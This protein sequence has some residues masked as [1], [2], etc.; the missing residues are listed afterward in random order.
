M[1][2]SAGARDVLGGQ[3]AVDPRP[4]LHHEWLAQVPGEARGHDAGHGVGAAARRVG[5]DEAHR[6]A[7]PL[8][9]LLRRGRGGGRVG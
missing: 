1:Q 7:G 9:R 2:P 4:V 8:T 3:G 5:H 6:P